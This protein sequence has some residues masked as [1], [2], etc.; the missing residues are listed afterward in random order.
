VFG[1][2]CG[3][4]QLAQSGALY[5]GLTALSARCEELPAFRELRARFT[6][7]ESALSPQHDCAAR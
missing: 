6:P 1:F 4:L 7:S 3:A 2:L 5:P